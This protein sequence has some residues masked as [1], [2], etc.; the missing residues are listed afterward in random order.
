VGL[1]NVRKAGLDH[2]HTWIGLPDYLALPQLAQEGKRFDFI[3]IDGYHSFDYA[4][5]DFFYSDLLLV[6]G[7]M[8][9]LHDSGSLPCIAYAIRRRE[10]GIHAC[11]ASA[12]PD[13]FLN[14]EADC[15]ASVLAASGSGGK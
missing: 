10:Q 9:V 4:M 6:S 13:S 7:G 11:G 1:Q 5:L 8:V 14:A 15:A 3:F 12:C 2:K